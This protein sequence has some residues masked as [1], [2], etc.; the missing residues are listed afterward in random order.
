M[1]AKWKWKSFSYLYMN[2]G[3]IKLTN[4]KFSQNNFSQFVAL[5]SFSADFVRRR[6]Q[7]YVC[8]EKFH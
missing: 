7:F 4:V 2:S 3:A 8:S 1:N 6:E 5:V